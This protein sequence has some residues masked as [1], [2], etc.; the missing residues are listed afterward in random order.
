MSRR[1]QSTG[2]NSFIVMFFTLVSRILGVIRIRVFASVFGA[3]SLADAI[4]FSFNIPNNLRKIFSEGALASAIVPGFSRIKEDRQRM[5]ELF[6]SL[7][8]AQ[9]LIGVVLIG[10]SVAVRYPFVNL[11]SGFSD[12]EQTETAASLLPYFNVFFVFILIAAFFSAV[13]QSL[14]AFLVQS[15]APLF[16]SIAEIASL[17]FLAARYGAY[18]MAYGAMAGGFLQTAVTAAAVLSKGL[19]LRL[20]FHFDSEDFCEVIRRWLPAVVTSSLAVVSTQVAFSIASSL[21]QGAVSAFSNSLVFWQTPYGIFFTAV[22]TVYMPLMSVA[23]GRE[24]ADTYSTGLKRL[25]CYLLPSAV[26]MIFFR[27]DIVAVV[28]MTG[29]FTLDNSLMTASVLGVFL[30]GMTVVAFY[31]FTQKL[32][33]CLNMQKTVLFTGI[34]VCGTDIALSVGLTAAGMGV[35]ALALANT[36]A[37]LTGLVVLLVSLKSSLSGF[38]VPDFL[39]YSARVVV[40]VL[41]LVLVC[42]VIRFLLPDYWTTGSNMAN[43]LTLGGITAGS[44]ALVLLSYRLFRIKLF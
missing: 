38:D 19:K 18:A 21:G 6:S 20:S 40:A 12:P 37:Y 16:F 2:R 7:L 36:V 27:R 34:V 4:N 13:L 14:S 22:G 30:G 31:S 5:Q 23:R 26:F 33:Y 8:T 25:L 24:L 17:V 1:P 41:P 15:L 29:R 35:S 43:L 28:L 39:R 42:S 9:L 44:V 11:L 32:C 10:F 3:G